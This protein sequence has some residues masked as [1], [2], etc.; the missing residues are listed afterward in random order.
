MHHTA[1]RA[2][3]AEDTG[4][5]ARA[6]D[7]EESSWLATRRDRRPGNTRTTRRPQ[8]RGRDNTGIMPVLAKAVREVE[9]AVQQR[10]L[11][12][13]QRS[14]FQ[15]IALLARAERAR[16]RVDETLTEARRDTELK[17][18][19]GVATILA[20]LAAA[21]PSLFV[22]LDENAEVGETTRSIQRE[23]QRAAGLEPVEEA[24]AP[25]PADAVDGRPERKVIP[26][27]VVAAQLANPFLTPDFSKA[28]PKVQGRLAGWELIGPL[29]N[30]FE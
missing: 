23:M 18:L 10:Q 25:T 3:G 1:G 19:D 13:R 28:A 5:S 11:D 21:E 20:Q 2:R 15:A 14:R 16:I 6:S 24:P 22:L 17:R 8:D 12:G 7:E 9:R 30:A 4:A 27:S 26:R 29:L